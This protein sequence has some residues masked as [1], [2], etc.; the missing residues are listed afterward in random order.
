MR[1]AFVSML[2]LATVSGVNA[3]QVLPFPVATVIEQPILQEQLFDATVEAVNQSTVSA[4]MAGRIESIAV[5][6]NDYVAKDAVILRFR[7]PEQRAGVDAAQAV[8]RETLARRTEAETQ[9]ARLQAVYDKHLVAKSALDKGS[10]DLKAAKAR[11]DAAQAGL[12]QA[13]DQLSHTEVRAPYSGIVVKRY[14]QIGESV[15]PGQALITGLSL[16][17]LRVVADIPQSLIEAVRGRNAAH[18][19]L[20]GPDQAMVAVSGLTVF[21]YADPQTHTFKV[22][23]NLPGG[24]HDIYPGMFLKVA[25]VTGEQTAVLV[26]VQAVV[27]RS[28]VTAVYVVNKSDHIALRQIRV[29]RRHAPA[30]LEVLAGL[31]VGERVALDPIRAGMYLKN[32]P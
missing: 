14:V 18:V 27:H 26:P 21:P 22:R 13:Q 28:E 32:N 29:G 11:L 16:D 15:N 9:F 8:L 1:Q 2:M 7:S 3:G 12:A 6:V 10:A 5:D 20:P 4:Q 19:F 24:L 25:F 17:S 30:S 23:V 31:Q